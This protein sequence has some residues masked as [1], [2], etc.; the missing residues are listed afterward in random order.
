MTTEKKKQ[1]KR[2]ANMVAISITLPDELGEKIK[3]RCQGKDET[4]SQYL[5]RLA[6]EDLAKKAA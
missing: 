5:R 2:D 1:P 3:Q 4:V 6:R